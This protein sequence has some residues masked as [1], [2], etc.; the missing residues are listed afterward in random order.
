MYVDINDVE[1]LRFNNCRDCNKCCYEKIFA[2][3]I[4]DDFERVYK[5]FPIFIVEVGYLRPVM[6]ISDGKN[7]CRY[8]EKGKCSI[9]ENRPP[10]CKIY[11]FSPWYDKILIDLSCPG[12]GVE[13]EL[14]PLDNFKDSKFYDKRFENIETKIIKTQEW[15][16]KKRLNK[17]GNFK[18]YDLFYPEVEDEFDEMVVNSH[19]RF[20]FK[21]F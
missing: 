6:I 2:P 20:Y 3:L 14:L 21:D 19:E 11:P 4:L 12:I 17:F 13:G 15:L 5:Y 1:F 7:P 10:A 18:G 8:L 16:S 9:Y